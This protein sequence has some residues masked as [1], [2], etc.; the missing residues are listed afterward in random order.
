MNKLKRTLALALVLCMMC[1]FFPVSAFAAGNGAPV[2]SGTSDAPFKQDTGGSTSFR[3]PALV[4]LSDGTLVAAADARWNTTY[5]GGGL[6][7]MVAVSEDNGATWTHSFANYL[8]DN[9]NVYNGASSCFIDPSLAVTADD[10]I[11]M[12]CDL[13]PNGVAL[14]GSKECTP[15]YASGFNA[16]G[17]LKLTTVAPGTYDDSHFTHYLDGDKIYANDGTVVADLTVD[18][19]FNVT[20][21]YNGAAVNSN[22]F[23]ADSPFHV[24]RTGYLYL[25]KSTNKGESWSEP[26][27][28]NLKTNNEMVCLVGPNGGMV[29]SKGVIVFPVY[30]YANS[31]ERT[32][33]IYSKDNGATWQRSP[34]LSVDSSEADAVELGNGKLRVFYR[35]R[36]GRLCYADY[37]LDAN[38]WSSSVDTGV[39]TNS[40]TELSAIKYSGTVDGKQVI[41]VSCPASAN[42]NGSASSD[43]SWRTSGRIFAGLVD[44]QTY[45]MT[46]LSNSVAVTPV[47]SGQLSGS[48]YT[49]AQGFFAYS[50][51]TERKDGSVYILYENN[52]YGWGASENTPNYYTLTNK[53][54]TRDAL[55]EA[56]GVTFGSNADNGNEGN[57]LSH[58]KDVT[59]KVGQTFT[60]KVENIYVESDSK[61]NDYVT[62]SWTGTQGTSTTTETLTAATLPTSAG[63][64]ECYISDGNGNYLTLSNGTLVN[65]T[66]RANATKWTVTYYD[67]SNSMARYK[68]TSGNYY[69]RLSNSTLAA[70]TSDSS[71]AHYYT[72]DKG[73]FCSSTG[74]NVWVY[75]NGW[76]LNN[77][78]NNAAKAY[79]LETA[80]EE[81]A[82]STTVTITGK[83][84]GQTTV[85]L[86]NGAI[87]YDVTVEKA[88]AVDVQMK[89]NETK[90]FTIQGS[91][92][93]DSIVLEPAEAIADM[94]VTGTS[95]VRELREI[96]S[97]DQFVSGK[98]Y[99]ITSRNG[100]HVLTDEAFDTNNNSLKIG[101]VV[102]VDSTELWTFTA[103]DKA[104]YFTIARNGKYLNIAD[105]R[106]T[107]GT[108]SQNL[109]VYRA[110]YNGETHWII[111]DGKGNAL[112]NSGQNNQKA[113]EYSP[114]AG[115]L[116]RIYEIV[117]T[118]A[119]TAVSFIGKAVG[120]TTAV[121][122]DTTYN[123]TV[124]PETTGE[125]VNVELE[126]GES[127]TLTDN[128]GNYENNIPLLPDTSIATAVVTGSSTSEMRLSENV[129]AI[130]SGK[131]YAVVNTRCGKLMNNQWADAS[132][133][134][135]GTN[136]LGLS[137]TKDNFQDNDSWTITVADGGYYVQDITGKYLTIAAGSASLSNDPVVLSVERN[138]DNW[139]IFQNGQY[140]NNY[141][142]ANTVVAGYSSRNDQNAQFQLCEITETVTSASTEITF[143][144]VAPGT[145]TAVVGNTLYN[146][147]VTS[148]GM[149]TVD[150]ELEIGESFTYTDTTGNHVDKVTQQPDGTYAT[151]A[152]SGTSNSTVRKLVPVTESTFQTGKRYII[153]NVRASNPNHSAYQP[154]HSVLTSTAATGGATGLVMDGPLNQ[155]TSQTWSFTPTANMYYVGRDNSYITLN[156]G[157]AYMSTTAQSLSFEY[158]DGSG[159]LIYYNQDG[160]NTSDDGDYF[161][162]DVYGTDSGEAF[163]YTD[164]DDDGNYWN[165][166]EVVDE[167]QLDATKVTFTGK[168]NGQTSAIVGNTQYNITVVPAKVDDEVMNSA[169]DV[170]TVD[171]EVQRQRYNTI[172]NGRFKDEYSDESWKQYEAA[173]QAAYKKLVEVSNAKYDSEEKAA[174]A[175]AELKA[176]VDAL[177][178]AAAKLVAATIISV[179][180]KLDNQLLDIREYKVL[181]TDNTLALP[182]TI[183]VD[184]TI[185]RVTNPTLVLDRNSEGNLN[186]SY[187]VAVTLVGAMGGGFVASEDVNAGSH[188]GKAQICDL[189]DKD[190]SGNITSR[191][192]IT[193]MTLSTGISYDLDLGTDTTG[194]TVT[195][196]SAN[197][198]IAT[199]DA[200]GNVTAVAAGTTMITATITDANG[201]QEINTIPVT[202][203][204]KGS[205]DRKTAIYIDNIDNTTVWCVLN[206]DTADH[207][208]EVIEGE[209]IYGQFDVEQPSGLHTTAISFFGDPDEAHAL[210]Y[211]KSTNSLDQYYLLHDDDG[212]L[213]DG[214]VTPNGDY[215]VSGTTGGAG[216]WHAVGLDNNNEGND[217]NW[218]PIKDM[219]RWAINLGCDGAFGFTRRRAYPSA[220]G[221]LASNLSFASDPLPRITKQVDG[222]LPTTRKQSDYRRY[223]E[224]MVAGV[225]ELVYFK[226]TVTLE[227]PTRWRPYVAGKDQ[228]Y[229]TENGVQYACDENRNKY[230]AISYHDDNHPEYQAIVSDTILPGAY[231]Y[232]K[233]RDQADGTWDGEVAVSERSQTE[234]ITTKLDAAWTEDELEAGKRVLEYFL[235][236]EI[237]E[238]DIPKFYI[239][240]V[241]NLDYYYK[242]HY[243]KGAQAAAADAEAR[244]TVVGSSIDSVVIDFG[245]SVTYQSHR[246]T[247][248]DGHLTYT[249]GG[250]TDE[251]LKG[252][253]YGE[254]SKATATYGDVQ[255]D[256][257][258]SGE[259]IVTYTPTSILQGSDAVQIFGRGDNNQEKVINGFLVYP[260]TSVYYE[261]GF[262]LDNN[263]GWTIHTD[264]EDAE[265]P[266][267][268]FELLGVSQFDQDNKLVG[269]ITNKKHAYG[270]DPIYD[271]DTEN[272]EVAKSWLSSS[273]VGHSTEFTF[274]GTGFELFANCTMSSSYITAEILN[275]DDQTVRFLMVNTVVKPGSTDATIG[276]TDT[277]DAL[278]IIS[279][280]DLEHGTYTVRL[281]KVMADGEDVFIDGVR[282]FNTISDS[283][284]YNVDLED[285]PKFYQMRD[286]VLNAI[287]I[288]NG[289]S[290]DYDEETGHTNLS[291][292]TKQVYNALFNNQDG[293]APAAVITSRTTPYGDS[294]TIQDMLDKGPKN[295]IYLW[296][297]QALSFHVATQRVIQVGLKAPRNGTNVIVNVRHTDTDYPTMDGFE[298][299]GATDMFY[300]LTTKPVGDITNTY[301]VSITNDGSDVLSITD[302]KICDD[303]NAALVPLTEDDV[304][305]ILIDA[306]YTD[307]SEPEVPDA[308]LPFV[309]VPEDAYFHDAVAWAVKHK[310]TSGISETHFGPDA[311]CTRAQAVTF[312]WCAAGKPAPAVSSNPF[313]DVQ[314]GSYY[315]QAVLWAVGEGITT[316]TDTT[317]FS[318]DKDCTRAQIVTFLYHAFDDPAVSST[319]IPFSDVPADVW[320]TAPI[321]WAAENGITSGV[322]DGLFGV[323]NTCSR[324]QIVTFLYKA[325]N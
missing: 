132:V 62:V 325:Y 178:A 25:T 254:N 8:G 218:Q 73:F 91:N 302:L 279:I 269:K 253:Y 7:T 283:S 278:P 188:E 263:T 255:V 42:L 104:E 61:E 284:I 192:K 167:P 249:F 238:S 205:G 93:E 230:S 10:T 237:Q 98:S 166:Y 226:I 174:A 211:M 297:G 88:D 108:D 142:N 227:A 143:K 11:Y 183:V 280:K 244:I 289:D 34:N 121:V 229:V 210:V 301:L 63:S 222:V 44:P 266:S 271:G 207:S 256:R 14:N 144:G 311:T 170:W 241:A 260:A 247:S 138:G 96:T 258:E 40:N 246:Y 306:G 214:T 129:T 52:Q 221:D 2:I 130:E 12:L 199:V 182:E 164:K 114:D 232:T 48:N 173:R 151:M 112:N 109:R 219:A 161:L 50:S 261:E 66:D 15:D 115:G 296:P 27:L 103:T 30:S 131:T 194:K 169:T 189:V 68:I 288:M 158:V 245:Q 176:R 84:A 19:W 67:H 162:S 197:D 154:G 120:R 55:E 239:D 181:S 323:N 290:G 51:M 90:N 165:I 203:F 277:M 313:E 87:S 123:I 39:K 159:W 299:N 6:D 64:I 133:G 304:R 265:N 233:E 285:N 107:M 209:L 268:T 267:Q 100:Q 281:T 86:G 243:S 155:D 60:E 45:E 13:Y 276:Q 234:V 291:G 318:P 185:Y 139:V 111:A 20:G 89:V 187:D 150:I 78:G 160:N 235:V 315:E 24:A 251:H 17:K 36:T 287:G 102:T 217:V 204:P 31:T 43:G 153:Q 127:K 191:K 57:T 324:A 190:D 175:L 53:T 152:V 79:T 47:A 95:A 223:T 58:E 80:T 3:I 310:I 85:E 228:Y 248:E 71:N 122:G 1:S 298:V 314:A 33:L 76:T 282:I 117:E 295:E 168:A 49:D 252:A 92:F 300:Y 146:I 141:G 305:Q 273:T 216:Y 293:E 198:G 259:Y 94:T 208:F 309:D 202:V 157:N 97:L 307:D 250:L 26:E 195:W 149:T 65:V 322:G 99:F 72:A 220:E 163:G 74:N 242:S 38:T 231:L 145:T 35:N 184:N 22:L 128:T 215:F 106:I 113:G 292:M 37:D 125:P 180:Y 101:G 134:G 29:T 213:Y 200:N 105:G 82:G 236:Y 275:A 18:E 119:S 240:N 70:G 124:L 148:A 16:N 321:L 308:P 206:A 272:G 116:W 319:E 196:T 303:P 316:G 126:V 59:V 46:W 9:G 137:S 56:L 257:T 136:G 201:N 140:L 179:S 225:H 186:T 32:G 54:F 135:G 28:L 171:P 270:Y 317:H 147:T 177:E 193:E 320:Y 274:T 77:T 110:T 294:S 212:N 81:T 83:K 5:D 23:F 172:I 286:A 118:P 312:L 75:N 69:V 156:G 21:T 264:D 224:N 4:T 41:L 262:I